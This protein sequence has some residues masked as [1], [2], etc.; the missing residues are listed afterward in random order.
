MLRQVDRTRSG[1]SDCVELFSRPVHCSLPRRLHK[2]MQQPAAASACMVKE[3]L[4]ADGASASKGV[5]DDVDALC[6]WLQREARI[7]DK[8]IGQTL[9]KLE[10]EHVETVRDLHELH[11]VG[12]L[13]DLFPRLTEAKV[14]AALAKLGLHE[15]ASVVTPACTPAAPTPQE[16]VPRPPVT[17]PQPPQSPQTQ[18]RRP[19][20]E[21]PEKP[22]QASQAQPG[23]TSIAASVAR[24][25]LNAPPGKGAVA[26]T[27]E[28]MSDEGS[29]EGKRR[30]KRARRKGSQQAEHG[31]EALAK[32]GHDQAAS[33]APVP[34]AAGP[35]SRTDGASIQTR[36]GQVS[37]A[38]PVGHR[39]HTNTP[40]SA[41]IQRSA[42]RPAAATSRLYEAPSK[43]PNCNTSAQYRHG[44]EV[45]EALEEYDKWL[46]G[47][48]LRDQEFS[49]TLGPV[50]GDDG[51]DPYCPGGDPYAPLRH[52]PASRVSWLL[53]RY[54]PARRNPE[55]YVVS[56]CIDARFPAAKQLDKFRYFGWPRGPPTAAEFERTLVKRCEDAA[57]VD[58]AMGLRARQEGSGSD[59]ADSDVDGGDGND[60]ND[61]N[62]AGDILE[63]WRAEDAAGAGADAGARDPDAEA[64]A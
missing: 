31:R 1:A 13:H 39:A 6:D 5:V 18:S 55:F 20:S 35:V 36:A 32:S 54:N 25:A 4:T 28:A 19:I 47:A 30:R 58:R 61:V 7:S 62:G 2:T 45:W 10:A 59:D 17:P 53:T 43:L 16:V 29:R 34:P 33:H 42:P 11:E 23:C 37:P 22:I 64:V 41:S 48:T 63:E 8:F 15:V 40:S 44:W 57:W 21:T 38:E 49:D 51:G 24:D 46:H 12:G 26:G 60:V 14:V 3:G 9:Q 52:M 27:S 56:Q 50:D